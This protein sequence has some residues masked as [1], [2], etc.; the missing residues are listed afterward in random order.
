MAKLTFILGLCGSGKSYLANSIKNSNPSVLIIDEGFNPLFDK[1]IFDKNYNKII[2]SLKKDIDC[3]VIEIALC[4]EEF[5]KYLISKYFS[6]IPGLIIEWKCF[7]NNIQKANKNLNNKN[8][9]KGDISGHRQIN[10][11]ISGNYTYPDNSV[12]LEIYSKNN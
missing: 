6:D 7:E 2:S 1:V 3:I 9:N 10:L 4:Q 11:N 8:R 12:I 5:R